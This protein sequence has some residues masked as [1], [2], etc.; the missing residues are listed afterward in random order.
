MPSPSPASSRSWTSG[1]LTFSG[2]RLPPGLDG[3][4]AA[5]WQFCQEEEWVLFTENRNEDGPDSLQATLT[6]RWRPGGLPVLTLANKARLERDREYGERVATEIAELL[7]GLSQ[8][9]YRDQ[10]RIYVP[11]SWP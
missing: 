6:E 9:D 7:F 3:T 11:R 4:C 2:L 10:P 5:L 1:S 8:G